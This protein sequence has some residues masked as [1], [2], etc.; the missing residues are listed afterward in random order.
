MNSREASDLPPT[1]S[2]PANSAQVNQ[3]AI[4][5]AGRQLTADEILTAELS[6][7]AA[8]N[9]LGDGSTNGRFPMRC[10]DCRGSLTKVASQIQINNITM[11]LLSLPISK[12]ASIRITT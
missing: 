2:Y 11:P 8:G 12:S 3:N 6:R 9:N 5:Y 1:P 7:D 10:Y 4:Y